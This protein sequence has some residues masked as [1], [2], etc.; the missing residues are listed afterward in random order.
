MTEAQNATLTQRTREAAT[1]AVDTTRDAATHAIDTTRDTASKAAHKAA[2]GI[3]SNPLAALIGGAALG[4]AIGALL[5]RT[6]KERQTLGPIGKR[7]TDS[8]AAAARSARDAGKQE[9]ESLM[10]DKQGAKDRAAALL[11]NVAKAAR[12]GAKT[13][14]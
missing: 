7:L 14:A 5:P 12:D 10:P 8:A 9:I 3:E 11:G 13:T 4:V 1:H 6:E 2:D